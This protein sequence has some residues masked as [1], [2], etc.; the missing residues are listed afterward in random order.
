MLFNYGFIAAA[1]ASE[2]LSSMLEGIRAVRGWNGFPGG[3][4]PARTQAPFTRQL[5]APGR[6]FLVA[7]EPV[8]DG[9]LR[10]K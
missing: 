3:R 10:R 2:S 8:S 5:L 6:D 4:G 7:R 1:K 9:G